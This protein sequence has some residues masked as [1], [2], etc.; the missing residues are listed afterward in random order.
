MNSDALSEVIGLPIQERIR[1]VQAIWD[2]VAENPDSVPV[3]PQQKAIL[4]QRLREYREN[5]DDVA[6][7]AE[8][9]RR[10]RSRD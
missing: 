1:A 9:E 4:E 5:P 6:S 2:S 8:V 10:L 7:W 3:T